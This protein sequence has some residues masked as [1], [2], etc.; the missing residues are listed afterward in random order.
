[1]DNGKFI[2]MDEESFKEIG[3]LSKREFNP[4]VTELVGRCWCYETHTL[5]EVI[6]LNWKKPSSTPE[7]SE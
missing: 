2:I 1:M 3:R 5:E 6:A 4:H 7:A